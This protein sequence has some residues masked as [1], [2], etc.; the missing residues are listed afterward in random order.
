[1]ETAPMTE[2]DLISIRALIQSLNFK[3]MEAAEQGVR[4]DL[5]ILERNILAL[6]NPVPMITAEFSKRL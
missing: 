2:T 6:P 5:S 4:I 1:M 3:I